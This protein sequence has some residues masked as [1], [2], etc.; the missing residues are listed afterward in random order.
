MVL[1][2]ESSFLASRDNIEMPGIRAADAGSSALFLRIHY[3]PDN[4]QAA[5]RIMSFFFAIRDSLQPKN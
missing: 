4:I 2:H 1:L 5:S 3:K